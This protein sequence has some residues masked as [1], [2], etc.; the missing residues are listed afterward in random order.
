[1]HAQAALTASRIFAATISLH[2][3]PNLLPYTLQLRIVL[4]RRDAIIHPPLR[5]RALVAVAEDVQGLQRVPGIY[6][7]GGSLGRERQR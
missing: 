4:H 2:E 3:T 1:M 7:F 5:Q 6:T